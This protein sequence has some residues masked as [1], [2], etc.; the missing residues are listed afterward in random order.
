MSVSDQFIVR[1]WR[2]EIDETNYEADDTEFEIGCARVRAGDAQSENDSIASKIG[3][4]EDNGTKLSPSSGLVSLPLRLYLYST[5]IY[6][7]REAAISCEG[8]RQWRN[9][10]SLSLTSK[11]IIVGS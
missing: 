6:R 9:G 11:C 2:G 10:K 1:S 8:R 7:P 3:D 5:Q 4:G